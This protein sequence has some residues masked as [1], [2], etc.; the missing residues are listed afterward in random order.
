MV[1]HT[2]EYTNN[3]LVLWASLQ[4]AR[5]LTAQWMFLFPSEGEAQS[6][7]FSPECALLG[8]TRDVAGVGK[9][10]PV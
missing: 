8:H 4:K 10:S 5:P 3:P 1:T 9:M 6:W 2:C 7:E